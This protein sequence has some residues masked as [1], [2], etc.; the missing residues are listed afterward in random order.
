MKFSPWIWAAIGIVF[1]GLIGGG[2][3]ARWNSGKIA[4]LRAEADSVVAVADSV[5]GSLDAWKRIAE[6]NARIVAQDRDSVITIIRTK[7]R[8]DTVLLAQRDSTGGQPVPVP[9]VAQADYNRL[10]ERCDALQSSCAS[11]LAA[12]DSALSAAIRVGEE[13]RQA[14]LRL[15]EA[16]GLVKPPRRFAFGV[17]GPYGAVLSGGEVRTGPGVAGIV[18]V[19]VF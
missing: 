14:R 4:K 11:A 5:R 9:V 19:R 7:I 3:G 10:A 1:A 16:L 2:L 18:T 17:C 8:V 12:K 6:A 13:E 15:D